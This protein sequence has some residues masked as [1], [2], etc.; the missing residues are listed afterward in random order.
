MTRQRVVLVCLVF[1]R[2]KDEICYLSPAFVRTFSRVPNLCIR[3]VGGRIQL[4]VAAAF[5]NRSARPEPNSHSAGSLSSRN[6]PHERTGKSYR[7]VGEGSRAKQ[8]RNCCDR[9]RLAG[10]H[11]RAETGLCI[12]RDR[13]LRPTVRSRQPASVCRIQ[14]QQ[15][16]I[17]WPRRFSRSALAG[18]TRSSRQGRRV[19][20]EFAAGGLGCGSPARN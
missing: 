2:R 5:T 16:R 15:F 8:S 3:L 18:Q 20:S 9:P 19:G 1:T 14:Q 17:C 12:A 13:G 4:S 11:T 7:R 6:V 10:G